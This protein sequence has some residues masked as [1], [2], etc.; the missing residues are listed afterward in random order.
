[1]I[2]KY[3]DNLL[4]WNLIYNSELKPQS[5]YIKLINKLMKKVYVHNRGKNSLIFCQRNLQKK[6]PHIFFS[7][8][9]SMVNIFRSVSL[10]PV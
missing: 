7:K 3:L 6:N 8:C 2:F 5:D 1:M 9:V 4:T 10:D